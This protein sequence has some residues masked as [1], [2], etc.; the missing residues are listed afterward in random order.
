MNAVEFQTVSHNGIIELPV[1]Q[2]AWNKKNCKSE[3]LLL[4][5]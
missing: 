3:E 5:G 2:Q 4:I 1:T